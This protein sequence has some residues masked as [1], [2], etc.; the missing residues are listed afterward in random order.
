[1]TDTIQRHITMLSLI[2]AS[3]SKIAARELHKRL[4]SNGF[5][6]DIR[7]VE[8]DL[9][10]LSRLFPLMSD[11]ARPAGWSWK[12]K[13]AGV[14][15]PRMDAS[16]ALGLELLSQYVKPLFPKSMLSALEPEFQRAR[17]VLEDFAEFPIGHWSRS[18][19]I[20]PFGQQLLPPAVTADVIEV[21]YRAL[22]EK[23]RFEA[24]YAA[25][26][27]AKAKRYT[28]N[29]LGLVYRA[30]VIYLVGSLWDYQ[31]IR[32]FALQRF[33][34]PSLLEDTATTPKGF[35]FERHVREE[36]A[37][38]FPEG[39]DFA[40]ELQVEP[41]LGKHLSESRLSADQDV[42][43]I[44]GSEDCKVTATVAETEQLI[45]WLRSLGPSVKVNKP[46]RLRDRMASDATAVAALYGSA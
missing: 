17:K 14:S 26:D 32:H 46:R 22:L 34:Q 5:E 42:K 35:N 3:P 25:A 1:M 30:G 4:Q 7:S 40:I 8:R 16:S 18:V 37:F 9:L 23:R 38:E 2:P 27:S 29:P 21:V 15:F 24:L 13:E 41:W 12:S 10:K 28:V 44:P 43:S 39:R 36:R 33:S 19:A 31:D 20:I 11:D 45:W 6:I